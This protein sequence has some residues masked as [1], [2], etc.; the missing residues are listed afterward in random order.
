[1]TPCWW[2][3]CVFI[4]VHQGSCDMAQE[5]SDLSGLIYRTWFIEVIPYFLQI[6]TCT[7]DKQVLSFKLRLAELCLQLLRMTSLPL[8]LQINL[9]STRII[10]VSTGITIGT[11]RLSWYSSAPRD[12]SGVASQKMA[13]QHSDIESGFVAVQTN[14]N[15][16]DLWLYDYVCGCMILWLSSHWTQASLLLVSEHKLCILLS[17]EA[18]Q[19]TQVNHLSSPRKANSLWVF[20]I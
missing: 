14:S 18:N 5:S 16:Y 13:L 10:P 6:R 2:L 9:E 15:L 4:A 3:S 17:A 11:V 12:C 8:C 20:T 7:V 19:P 1:M